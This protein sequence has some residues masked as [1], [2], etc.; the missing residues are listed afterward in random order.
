M[1]KRYRALRLI[2]TVYKVLGVI[3][4]ALTV[5]LVIGVCLSSTLGGAAIDSFSR[6]FR[7]T[8]GFAA[9]G[10]AI[11]G[12]TFGVMMIIYGGGLSITLY[13]IGESIYLALA[14]EENTRMTTALLRQQIGTAARPV[15]EPPSVPPP[16]PPMD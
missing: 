2:G 13:A 16:D 10:G 11:W 3:V 7:D 4:A 9:V 15:P 14:I 6:E 1:E 12:L 5:L 8:P